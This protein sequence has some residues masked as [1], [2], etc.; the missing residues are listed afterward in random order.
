MSDDKVKMFGGGALENCLF[1]KW[2]VD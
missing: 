2:E 1:S